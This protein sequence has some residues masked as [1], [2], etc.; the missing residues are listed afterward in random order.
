MS[1]F[2]CDECGY[3]QFAEPK[4]KR[5]GRGTLWNCPLCNTMSIVYLDNQNKNLQKLAREWAHGFP[6]MRFS[7]RRV[8]YRPMNYLM[9]ALVGAKHFINVATESMDSF[10]LGLL[11]LKFFEQDI[12]IKVILWHPQ[13]LYETQKRL[14]DNSILL[15]D[16]RDRER[17]LMR[18]ISID[19]I[20]EVHQKLI[21]IDGYLALKGSV[22]AT[23]AG[24]SRRGENVEFTVD[25]DE[26]QE[27]NTT[28]FAEFRAAKRRR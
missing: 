13:R 1:V 22:N 28:L 4:T 10:F 5:G 3:Y 26:V 18:G 9:E 27:L 8:Q 14:W 23:L 20:N 24:W 11:S 21:V 2:Y 15:K 17:F 19:I 6:R 7:D 16:Y 12:E 25:P